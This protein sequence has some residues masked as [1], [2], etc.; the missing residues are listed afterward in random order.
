MYFWC[1]QVPGNNLQLIKTGFALLKEGLQMEGPNFVIAF[2]IK[3]LSGTGILQS[4]CKFIQQLAK[5][6]NNNSGIFDN[7]V[8]NFLFLTLIQT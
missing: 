4:A 8:S 2:E 7:F 3:A 6:E 5:Y 1:C